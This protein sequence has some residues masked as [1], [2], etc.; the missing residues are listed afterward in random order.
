MHMWLVT[1]HQ[2]QQICYLKLVSFK[3]HVRETYG[4]LFLFAMPNSNLLTLF[5][6]NS[7]IQFVINSFAPVR[8]VF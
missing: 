6:P 4:C 1:E 2:A 7:H 5:N 8:G 3:M